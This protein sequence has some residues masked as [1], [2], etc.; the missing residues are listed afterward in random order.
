MGLMAV[1]SAAEV[2]WLLS[3]EGCS[4]LGV[5]GKNPFTFVLT[6]NHIEA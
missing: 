2:R 6:N 4:K 5:G 1:F 3:A